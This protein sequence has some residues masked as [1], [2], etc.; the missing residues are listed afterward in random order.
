MSHAYWGEK[1]SRTKIERYDAHSKSNLLGKVP[2]WSSLQETAR[3]AI[4]SKVPT[5][6]RGWSSRETRTI[7]QRKASIS[8]ARSSLR[9]RVVQARANSL[10]QPGT[11]WK[12]GNGIVQVD[13][14]DTWASDLSKEAVGKLL[15]TVPWT[16][17]LTESNAAFCEHPGERPDEREQ[18]KITQVDSQYTWVSTWERRPSARTRCSAGGP[19]RFVHLPGSGSEYCWTASSTKELLRAL[20]K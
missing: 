12:G 6:E 8:G 20:C 19:M 7:S 1:I 15:H 17:S 13:S 10:K 11:N 2:G 3:P 14:Q 16:N 18:I 5:T 9:L 4:K